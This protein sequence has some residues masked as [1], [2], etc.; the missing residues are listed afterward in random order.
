MTALTSK[1][2]IV[3]IVGP[4]ASGKSGLALATAIEL[5]G[6]IIN[7]DSMQ[8][9]RELRVLTARPDENDVALAPHK[10][11]GILPAATACSVG[12]W[13]EM[14]TV[15]IKAA[16]DEGKLPILTGG[17]GLYF[18]SL[19]GG[20][21]A[22]PD[23]PEKIRQA[24]RA[25]QEEIGTPALH[26]E[27]AEVDPVSAKR[28]NPSD[29]QRIIRAY[30]VYQATRRSLTSWHA[31]DPA[32][33]PLDARY[34]VIKFEPPRDILYAS[35]EARFDWMFDHGAMAEVEALLD[36]KLNRDLPAMKALGVAELSRHLAGELNKEE[37]VTRAKR[38]TR[39]YAKRQLT[40]FRNQINAS[41]TI[42]AQYSESLLPE[43]FPKIRKFV[44]TTQ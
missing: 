37:A 29:S 2:P 13:Q 4:T 34:H 42:F 14:A 22:I 44:L 15:G 36:L 24:A 1:K 26:K 18:K 32:T 43:I 41:E 27:L 16:W 12:Q 20:L 23:I 3:M 21:S 10:L 6:V 7:A 40:W 38:V 28:L 17:T 30:E 35:C 39:N 25:K 19:M 31:D 11:Y 33:P 9:Y 8:V 5:N